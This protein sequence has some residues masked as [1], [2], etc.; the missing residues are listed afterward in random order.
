MDTL[1]H[2]YTRSHMNRGLGGCF[3]KM[4][5]STILFW[6]FINFN[7]LSGQIFEKKSQFR[8]SKKALKAS[9]YKPFQSLKLLCFLEVRIFANK[10]TVRKSEIVSK[11]SVFR[12]ITKLWIWIFVPKNDGLFWF[13][14]ILFLSEFY[15]KKNVK[16]PNFQKDFDTAIKQNYEFGAKIQVFKNSQKWLLFTSKLQLHNFEGFF[17]KI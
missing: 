8:N 1:L 10:H 2:R 5:S 3:K 16:N 4:F 7:V 13:K 6:S 15:A 14:N 12:K 9:K 11:K 17:L